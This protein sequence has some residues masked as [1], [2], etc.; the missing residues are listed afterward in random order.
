MTCDMC[1]NSEDETQ[2]STWKDRINVLEQIVE[3]RDKD[4]KTIQKEL[5]QVRKQYRSLLRK[6]KLT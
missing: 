6:G 4:L 1:C 2:T 5:E 3:R